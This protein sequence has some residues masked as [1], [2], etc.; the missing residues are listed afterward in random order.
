LAEDLERYL[1]DEP[2]QA[3]RVGRAERVW[4]WCQRNPAVTSL[5]AA[6]TLS[7]VVGAAVSAWFAVEA[8]HRAQEAEDNAKE[9]TAEKERANRESGRARRSA[10][11]ALRNLYL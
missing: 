6:V 8:S 11:D 5:L 1:K 4:R 10:S 3:R 9:A 7:L 2:I